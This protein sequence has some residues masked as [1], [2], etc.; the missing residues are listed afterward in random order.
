[1]K[2]LRQGNPFRFLDD[3][4]DLPRRI[5]GVACP[6]DVVDSYRT[7]FRRGA[8]GPEQTLPVVWQHNDMSIP[9]GQARAYDTDIG[10]EFEGELFV[11][12]LGEARALARLL[13][14]GA[15][16]DCSHA[17]VEVEPMAPDRSFSSVRMLEISP[18]LIGSNPAAYVGARASL[19]DVG[20][21]LMQIDSARQ[22]LDSLARI[23]QYGGEGASPE[24]VAAADAALRET[25]K[26]AKSL[27]L[28]QE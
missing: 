1:M 13:K 5:A 4:A 15:V 22:A 24:L 6:W 25:V 10:R 21:V 14:S 12:D 8:F 2:H 26:W 19:S 23:M 11:D 7:S 16:R 20:Y 28:I 27:T 3:S 9:V 17:F 18:V